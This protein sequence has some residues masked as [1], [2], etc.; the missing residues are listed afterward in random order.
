MKPEECKQVNDLINEIGKKEQLKVLDIFTP[1]NQYLIE[2]GRNS[3]NV[4]QW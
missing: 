1:Y 2:N 3:L 4:R